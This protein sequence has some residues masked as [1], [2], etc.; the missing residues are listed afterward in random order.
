MNEVIRQFEKIKDLGLIVS[1]EATFDGQF[2]HVVKKFG[3]K[4]G[5]VLR[6]FDNKSPMFMKIK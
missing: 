6:A 4:K 5:L 3:Q 1:E 2:Y